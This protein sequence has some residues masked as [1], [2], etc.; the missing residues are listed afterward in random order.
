MDD[1]DVLAADIVVDLDEDL[2][3]FEPFHPRIGEIRLPTAIDG[4][5][6]GD[7]LRQRAVRVAR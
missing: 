1:E 4:D 5:A 3:V 7:R 6:L 2:A